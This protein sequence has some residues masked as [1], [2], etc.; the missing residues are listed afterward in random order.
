MSRFRAH[1]RRAYVRILPWAGPNV[2]WTVCSEAALLIASAAAT[3]LF[4][5]GFDSALI[6]AAIGTA[7]L[8]LVFVG[9]F[10]VVLGSTARH[11][12]RHRDW[13]S[14]AVASE[15]SID[16][17]LERIGGSNLIYGHRCRVMHPNGTLSTATDNVEGEAPTTRERTCSFLYAKGVPQFVPDPPTAVSGRYEVTWELRFKRGAEWCEVI[18]KPKRSP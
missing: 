3:L 6:A 9:A 18:H 16:L 15:S 8:V 7:A 13:R 12:E 2:L 11:P 10:F 1:A 4:G 17:S 14:Q 5:V